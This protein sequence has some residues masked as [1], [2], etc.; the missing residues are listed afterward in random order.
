MR[1]LKTRGGETLIESLVSILIAA[2]TF[3]FL[4]TAIVTAGKINAKAK[5]TDVSFQYTAEAVQS[6]RQATVQ[7]ES[8]KRSSCDVVLYEDKGYHY[9]T[10]TA[11]V[12]AP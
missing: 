2:L 11:E 8:G 3:A 9:Y 7:G 12:S 4:A 1:K 10:E 6:H 5:Q